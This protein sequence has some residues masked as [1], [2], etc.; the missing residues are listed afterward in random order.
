M[1]LS[2]TRLVCNRLL[3]NQASATMQVTPE[4]IGAPP[5]GSIPQPGMPGGP[6]A[7]M[8]V[9]APVA[10]MGAPPGAT[11]WRLLTSLRTSTLST[12]LA[13]LWRAR[14]GHSSCSGGRG[15]K[16]P[17]GSLIADGYPC[18]CQHIASDEGC[19]CRLSGGAG[20]TQPAG[21]TACPSGLRRRPAT[22][23]QRAEHCHLHEQCAGGC[24]R[25]HSRTW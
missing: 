9:A 13:W 24:W 11:S 1:Y 8:P 17:E 2:A 3:S 7:E 18:L 6:P 20:G 19:E 16:G 15:T 5:A 22:Y 4:I 21:H 10:P 12:P 25:Y 14:Y 23:R